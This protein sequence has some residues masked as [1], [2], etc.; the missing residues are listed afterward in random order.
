MRH[1]FDESQHSYADPRRLRAEYPVE[2]GVARWEKTHVLS[3]V[4][5]CLSSDVDREIMLQTAEG[6]SLREIAPMVGITPERVRQ[7][8]IKAM[9]SMREMLADVG[10]TSMHDFMFT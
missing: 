7:R 6:A 9:S 4:I 1:V 5:A 2:Q 8:Q 3:A 10:I